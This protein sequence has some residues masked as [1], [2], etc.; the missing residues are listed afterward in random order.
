MNKNLNEMIF[1]LMSAE[2]YSGYRAEIYGEYGRATAAN[3]NVYYV[4]RKP[5][6]VWERVKRIFL[7][8]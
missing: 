5:V 4:F 2:C 7:F 1:P 6:T 8:R 3:D